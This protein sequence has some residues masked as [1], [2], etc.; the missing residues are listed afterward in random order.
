M[1]DK[2]LIDPREVEALQEFIDEYQLFAHNPRLAIELGAIN[3]TN[4]KRHDRRAFEQ[5]KAKIALFQEYHDE[6]P[7]ILTPTP[8]DGRF[9]IATQRTN[10]MPISL[11]DDELQRHVL[12]VGMTGAGKTSLAQRIADG[13]KQEGL[14]LLI[15]DAKQDAM[16]F[17]TRYSE[18]L[19]LHEHAPV[20]LLEVPSFLSREKYVAL[21]VRS[22]AATMWGGEGLIQ[23]ATES[24]NKTFAEHEHPSVRDVVRVLGGMAHKGDTYTRRDRIEGLSQRLERLS[25]RYPGWAGTQA[26][27]GLS[28]DLIAS[29][30][31]YFGFPTGHSEL[32]DFLSTLLVELRFA[33]HRSIGNRFLRALVLI[34][35]SLL[36]FHEHGI[37]EEAALLPTIPLLREFGI[38]VIFTANSIARLPHAVKANTYTKIAMNLAD[39]KE[40]MEVKAT[41][42]L[43]DAQHEYLDKKL[44]RGE[45]IMRLGDRWR[46]PILATFTPLSVDKHTSTAAWN[47]AKERTDR[48]ARTANPA[49]QTVA[50]PDVAK[51]ALNKNEQSLLDYITTNDPVLISEATTDLSLHPQVATRALDKLKALHLVATERIIVRRGRGGTAIAISPTTS[52]KQQATTKARSTRGGDSAQHRYLATRIARRITGAQLDLTIGNKPID[53]TIPYHGAAHEHLLGIL[54]SLSGHLLAP[55]DGDIIGIEIETR[56]DKTAANNITKNNT[57]GV[58]TLIATM[59]P[60]TC[61]APVVDALQLLE[62]LCAT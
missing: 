7:F 18:M 10:D 52:G 32:E 6:Y 5:W 46:Y 25:Q 62:A 9:P 19:V 54:R 44:A 21:F 39:H 49:T 50:K 42:G 23:V 40:T 58:I 31:W 26:G 59:S 55:N 28:S 41:F 37:R 27:T 47:H 33:Y 17:P 3:I 1:A 15:L 56:P 45:V 29:S 24:L 34:D 13:A 57:A 35:E 22:L 53:I 8:L 20:P 14:D 43:T 12:I 11:T 36:L 4:P 48:R 51:L 60:F 30:S 16:H 61:E 38:G 2:P